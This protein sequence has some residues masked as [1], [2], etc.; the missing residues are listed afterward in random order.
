MTASNLKLHKEAGQS[1]PVQGVQVGFEG[2]RS[3]VPI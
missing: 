2:S 3:H 1:K